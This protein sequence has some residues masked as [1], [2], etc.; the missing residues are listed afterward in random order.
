MDNRF[1]TWD[2]N[3][4]S[5]VPE[6]FK[7]KKKIK[8]KKKHPNQIYSNSKESIKQR[9]HLYISVCDQLLFT[10]EYWNMLLS[11]GL[12]HSWKQNLVK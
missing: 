2:C 5:R 8:N 12:H 11:L 1:E 6:D 7:S 10:C 9:E 3:K 4:H